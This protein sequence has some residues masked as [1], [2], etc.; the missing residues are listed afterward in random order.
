MTKLHYFIVFSFIFMSNF[1]ISQP[2]DFESTCISKITDSEEEKLMMS[3]FAYTAPYFFRVYNSD[4]GYASVQLG[5]RRGSGAFLYLKIYIFNTCLRKDNPLELIF[6]NSMRRTI[7]SAYNLNCDG[8]IVIPL[9][10]GDLKTIK[11][12]LLTNIIVPA[13]QNKYEFRISEAASRQIQEDLMCLA[14]YK[15]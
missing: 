2:K 5:R 4:K 15:F 14:K 13:F 9:K 12:N 11:K 10:K 1:S 3:R 7:K 6:S 8:I